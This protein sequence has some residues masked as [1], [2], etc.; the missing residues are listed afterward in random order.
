VFAP[1]LYEALGGRVP[2]ERLVERF[3]SR[4]RTHPLLAPAFAQ[5]A[6]DNPDAWWAQHIDKLTDFWSSVAGGPPMYQG[7]PAPAHEGFGI[8]PEH[9]DV[10]LDLWREALEETVPPRAAADLYGRASR[11]R[12]Q[13]ERYLAAGPFLTLTAD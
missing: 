9:F 10:W 1:T 2:F 13:L 6:G 8:G 4:A 7:R 12:R 5:A 3:Y 11:M